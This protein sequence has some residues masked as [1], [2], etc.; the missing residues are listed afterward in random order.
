MWRYAPTLPPVDGW[1]SVTLGEGMTPT[2]PLTGDVVAK[3]DFLNPTLSFKDRGAAVL[4]G[5]AAAAGVERV[6]VD[7]SGNA[8]TALAA[9]GARAGIAV[10][11]WVPGGTSP[12]KTA[13]MRAHGADVRTV[14]GDRAAAAGA[15]GARVESTGA[16]YASH[17][18][19]PLFFQGTKTAVL[20]LWEQLGGRLPGTI[21]LPAGNGTLV[22]G[23][24]LAVRDLAALGLIDRP[25][26]L[27]A[28]QARRCAPL[29]GLDP[30]GPTVAEG[31]AIASPPRRDE[32]LAVVAGTGGAVVT[33]TEEAVLA[34]RD[35][36]AD[37]GIWVEP[38]AAATWAACRDGSV[39][40]PGTTVGIVLCG[41]GLKS[42]GP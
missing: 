39:A 16:F 36:L 40:P 33:V 11:V 6:V 14:D 3:L 25:P 31:I 34:A 10:E 27:V 38:T 8:G 35:D 2:V 32:I 12:G 41:A 24:G 21:A 23:A 26:R 29:A 22:L 5:A 1:R 17:V 19:Q 28:V 15:A 42:P 20:E 30:D 13:A 7:S 4:I 9:Y 18:Y 37:R